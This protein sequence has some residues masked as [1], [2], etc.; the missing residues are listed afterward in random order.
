[1]RSPGRET[2]SSWSTYAISRLSLL[3]A[4]GI[5]LYVVEG[6]LPRPVPWIRLGLSNVVTLVALVGFGF[7]E[8]FAV[9]F[10]RVLLGALISGSLFSPA[11]LFSLVGAG[12]SVSLMGLTH[13]RWKRVF[14]PIGISIFGALGHNITQLTLAYLLFVRKFE[15]LLMAPF[16]IFLS[17]IMGS[18]VGVAGVLLL[19]GMERAGLRHREHL[20]SG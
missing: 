14:S 16:V 18:V 11:F 7:G 4:V 9:G 20:A 15:L 6:Y 8:A 13:L 2:R 10:L 17:V 3:V 1:M 12:A 19:D 5:A